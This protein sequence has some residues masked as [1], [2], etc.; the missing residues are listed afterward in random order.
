MGAPLQFILFY[1]A[2]YKP[3]DRRPDG[4]TGAELSFSILLTRAFRFGRQTGTRE[5]MTYFPH[6]FRPKCIKLLDDNN[7]LVNIILN[8]ITF[9]NLRSIP[10]YSILVYPSAAEITLRKRK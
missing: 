3:G 2:V 5:E 9:E 1:F 4:R 6:V 10:S 7:V 8:A